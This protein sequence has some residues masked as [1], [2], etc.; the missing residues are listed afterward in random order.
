[1][2]T[3]RVKGAVVERSITWLGDVWSNIQQTFQLLQSNPTLQQ[4]L[5]LQCLELWTFLTP[6]YDY[7]LPIIS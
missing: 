6:R 1:M 5:Q 3:V 4:Q 7:R 2:E